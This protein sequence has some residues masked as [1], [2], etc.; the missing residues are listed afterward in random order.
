M[1]RI[2]QNPFFR[3]DSPVTDKGRCISD[4]EEILRAK[5][6]RTNRAPTYGKICPSCDTR[7]GTTADGYIDVM[8]CGRCPKFKTHRGYL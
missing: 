5:R 8:R 3:P 6:R 2:I 4:A 1:S 7:Y